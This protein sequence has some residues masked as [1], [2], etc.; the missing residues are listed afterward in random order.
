MQ[1]SL[2]KQ[3]ALVTGAS[4]G[5]GAAAAKALAAA[6]AAVVVNYNS[7][8]EPAERLVAEIRE[9]GGKAIAVGAD[10]SKEDDVERLFAA[11]IDTYGALDILVAN[12]GLQRD[13]ATVDMT[14]ADWNK[15]IEVN[16]TGQFLCA[17]AALR[18]FQK[19]GPRSWLSRAAGKIIHMS[20]VH[21]LIPWAGHVNYAASKGGIDLLMRSI[22]Q[23]V[24]EQ[25]IR[26]NS[27]APGAI[28]TAI[29]EENTQGDAEKKLLE[30]IPYG[31]VGEV[32]D[33]ANAV[34]WLASDLSDYVHGTTLFIDGGM[35]LYPGFRNN[36]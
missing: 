7:H 22:A 16:L 26:V 30:L 9:G 3:V 32:D 17:R 23:E 35:S 34:V 11:T 6:G 14:L 21:Q 13:A 4:S 31:R 1:I 25:R 10:V 18:Q 8:A 15:V 5:L 2:D 33:V 36:G 24:G 19:Q 20:S 29:N 28:R 27:I 12:S